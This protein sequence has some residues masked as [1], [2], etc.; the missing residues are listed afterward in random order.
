MEIRDIVYE[1]RISTGDRMAW[2]SRYHAHGEGEY[3][4]HYFLEGAGSFLNHRARYP[5][6]PETLF[7][8]GPHEFHSIIPD[9]QNVQKQPISYYAV[10]FTLEKGED[11]CTL[12]NSMI[13]RASNSIQLNS[14]YHFLFETMLQ[15]GRS[16]SIHQKKAA[17][18]QL[19]SFLYAVYGKEID[20]LPPPV[21]GLHHIQKAIEVMRRGLKKKTHRGGSC[22]E[23]RNQQRTL[24]SA[25]PTSPPH[26]AFAVCP[27]PSCRGGFGGGDRH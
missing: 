21:S 9:P 11:L 20:S 15:F 2:H 25:I 19:L 4:L 8:T 10:L 3:E 22:P 14:K 13:G 27:S 18:Y 12:L 6:Q 5:I 23:G 16:P 24:D 26:F 17:E 1:Y 7:L